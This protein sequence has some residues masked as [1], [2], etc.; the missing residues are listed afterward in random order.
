MASVDIHKRTYTFTVNTFK[1]VHTMS[2]RSD[3]SVIIKQLVRSSSSI[4]ANVVEAQYSAT[5]KVFVYCMS[6]ALRSS[7][8]TEYWLKMC[9]DCG[10]ING[11]KA[12]ELIRECTEI[13][14]II[15]TIRIKASGNNY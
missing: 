9:L 2:Y 10:L 3:T 13:T 12:K 4:G 8:E 5:K 14:K 1:A 15:A 11:C 7:R 6:I